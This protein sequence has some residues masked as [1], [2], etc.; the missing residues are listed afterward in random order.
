M[1]MATVMH[2]ARIIAAISFSFPHNAP[3]IRQAKLKKKKYS[4]ST[5]ML[6]LGMNKTFP[7]L[8][9]HNIVFARDYH[10]NTEDKKDPALPP[11]LVTARLWIIPLIVILFY[12]QALLL[13]VS[14]SGVKFD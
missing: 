9:H 3:K 13:Y 8:P 10:Q 5:F 11:E 1:K 4:C 12:M 14:I 2:H 7:D 6:Y